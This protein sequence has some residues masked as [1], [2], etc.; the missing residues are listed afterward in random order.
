VIGVASLRDPRMTAE[1]H[2]CALGNAVPAQL[3]RLRTLEA[4]FDPGTFDHLEA[5]GPQVRVHDVLADD[6]P[7]D[8]FD[9]IL[10]ASGRRP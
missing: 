8:E 10:A 9:V 5:L 6:L 3:E 7:E 4:L 1:E 2:A